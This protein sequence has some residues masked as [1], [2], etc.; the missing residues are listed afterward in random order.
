MNQQ[1]SI[2]QG[3]LDLGEGDRRFR[4]PGK[5]LITLGRFGQET[6]EWLQDMCITQN[7]PM[8]EVDKSQEAAQLPL[9]CGLWKLANSVNLLLQGMD[10]MLVHPMAQKVK[11]RDTQYTL[12]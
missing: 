8:I 2:C 1:G 11:F 5:V 10:T 9:R 7:E 12:V 3:I 4:V 6:V